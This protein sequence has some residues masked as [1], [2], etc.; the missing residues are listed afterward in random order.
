MPAE[1]PSSPPKVRIRSYPVREYLGL[2]YAY[3]GEGAAPEL[4]RFRFLEEEGVLEADRFPRLCNYFN[5]LE[6]AADEVHI[7]FVHG[8]QSDHRV[9]RDLPAISAEESE[10]GILRYGQRPDGKVRVS[11]NLMPNMVTVPIP[12]PPEL[13]GFGGWR[14]A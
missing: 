8:E 9:L 1:D 6:N 14:D 11:H 12:P 5:E 3:L 4:P 7:H 13:K 10:Y 2:I